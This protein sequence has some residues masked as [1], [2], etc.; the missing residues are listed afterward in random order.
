MEIA[1]L[2]ALKISQQPIQA[3]KKIISLEHMK[4]NNYCNKGLS[5]SISS[6]A[7]QK[8][9][10]LKISCNRDRKSYVLMSDNYTPLFT[11]LLHQRIVRVPLNSSWYRTLAIISQSIKIKWWKCLMKRKIRRLMI[12]NKS[13]WKPKPIPH[14]KPNLLRAQPW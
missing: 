2:F 6:R 9:E 4:I 11:Q 13:T 10:H 3:R 5:Q 8:Q 12:D 1:I 7:S 14:L